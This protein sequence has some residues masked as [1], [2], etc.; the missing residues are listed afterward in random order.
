MMRFKNSRKTI[1]AEILK[2]AGYKEYEQKDGGRSFQKRFVDTKGMRYFTKCF[3]FSFDGRSSWEFSM[4]L[5]T[6][7]GAVEF[8][9]IQWFNQDSGR[10]IKDVE[11]YFEWL[12]KAHNKPYYELY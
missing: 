11:D 3:Y 1:S 2:Q 12:W 5:E 10:T 4:Q 7:K 6:E 9:T 8:T